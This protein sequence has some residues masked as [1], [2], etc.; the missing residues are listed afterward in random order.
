LLRESKKELKNIG[1]GNRFGVLIF[2]IRL[3]K[4]GDCTNDGLVQNRNLNF[5]FSVEGL[6]YLSKKKRLQAERP[7]KGLIQ[8][9]VHVDGAIVNIFVNEV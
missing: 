3:D 1:L 2:G 9:I 7:V 4:L 8:L 5:R 6:Q